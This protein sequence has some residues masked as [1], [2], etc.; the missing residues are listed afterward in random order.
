[1]NLRTTPNWLQPV[2]QVSFFS[3]LR[4]LQDIL[5]SFTL[6]SRNLTCLV[7]N[8]YPATTSDGHKQQQPQQQHLPFQSHPHHLLAHKLQVL[9]RLGLLAKC[10]PTDDGSEFLVG[11]ESEMTTTTTTTTLTPPPSAEIFHSPSSR[12]YDEEEQLRKAHW[13]QPGLPR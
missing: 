1:M 13:Y 12:V 2:K 9:K 6:K 11:S 8:L 7:N 5:S 4:Y 3:T 10:S